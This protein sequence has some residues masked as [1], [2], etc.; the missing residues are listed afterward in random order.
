LVS[1][2][3]ERED[4]S[5]RTLGLLALVIANCYIEGFSSV[6]VLREIIDIQNMRMDKYFTV[7][8]FLNFLYG[9]CFQSAV[10]NLSNVLIK[11]N[12][13]V[14]LYYLQTIF[15]EFYS[16]KKCPKECDSLLTS[17]TTLIDQYPKGCNFYTGICELRDKYIAH[18]DRGKF[19]SQSGANVKITLD[20]IELAYNRLSVLIGELISVLDINP[21]LIDYDQLNRTNL[22]SNPLV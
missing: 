8:D 12:D 13:S 18:I 3:D 2:N 5:D 21:D 9:R 14:N 7:P 22:H 20:E 17:I 19:L 10:L 11:N 1:K 16:K 4:H 6:K 15:L